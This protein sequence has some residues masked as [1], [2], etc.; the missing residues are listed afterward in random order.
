M[1]FPPCC[2][3][4]LVGGGRCNLQFKHL[5]Q[6][7]S[8]G[9]SWRWAEDS[10][11][12]PLQDLCGGKRVI[13]IYFDSKLPWGMKSVS[14]LS[15]SGEEK[16]RV[17]ARGWRENLDKCTEARLSFE[18][19]WKLGSFICG[20]LIQLFLWPKHSRMFPSFCSDLSFPLNFSKQ[21]FLQSFKC[22]S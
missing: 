3:L 5:Q 17:G 13:N 22:S 8:W 14:L 18:E 11:W 9:Q 7:N 2:S 16:P 4:L 15:L 10:S 19:V 21:A 1:T 20:I 6:K 12:E